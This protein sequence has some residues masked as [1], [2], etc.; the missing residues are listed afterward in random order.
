MPRQLARDCSGSRAISDANCLWRRECAETGLP[1]P[2]PSARPVKAAYFQQDPE[3]PRCHS[4][5]PKGGLRFTAEETILNQLSSRAHGRV[6]ASP[7][8][9]WRASRRTMKRAAEG[10][11][12]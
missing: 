5:V 8:F 1:T 4:L 11:A 9:Y 10:P 12:K 2:G 3:R 7:L 6:G